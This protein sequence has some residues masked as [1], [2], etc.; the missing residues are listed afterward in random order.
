MKIAVLLRKTETSSLFRKALLKISAIKGEELYL[1]SG[2]LTQITNDPMFLKYV[3]HGFKGIKGSKII[4]LGMRSMGDCKHGVTF[5]SCLAT[6]SGYCNAC[7]YLQFVT[8][9]RTHG[10]ASGIFTV[11]AY[12]EV[13]DKWHAKVAIKVKDGEP[14]AAIIGSSNLTIP[15]YGEK[16]SCASGKSHCPIHYWSKKN[17]R[18][19][20]E[21]DVLFWDETKI[22]DLATSST[23]V[24]GDSV[25]FNNDGIIVAT[26]ERDVKKDLIDQLDSIRK[27]IGDTTK[28]NSI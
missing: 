19:P 12:R 20:F 6:R 24:D 5:G 28:V 18:F 4:T 11:N 8:D 23:V 27:L 10:S 15:A 26:P 21:C 25:S 17:N 14:I 13:Q 16:C 9:L 1:C 7:K 22:K 3:S 2:T